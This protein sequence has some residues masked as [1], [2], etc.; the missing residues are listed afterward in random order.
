DGSNGDTLLHPVVARF[1]HSTVVASGG[2]VKL[3]SGR[4]EI[5]L[6]LTTNDARLED[7]LALAVKASTAPM[8]GRV[9]LNT[10]FDLPPGDTDLTERLKLD[11]SFAI[12]QG[13]F[14]RAQVRDKIL[15]LSRRSL[16]KPKDDSAGS[17]ITELKGRFALRNGVIDFSDLVFS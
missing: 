17:A 10:D 1:L 6:H 12:E 15:E 7:L 16:G 4:R 2:V 9:K 3:P 8:S 5:K 11:G 14:T 13:Q